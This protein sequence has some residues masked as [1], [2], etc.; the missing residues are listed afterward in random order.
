MTNDEILAEVALVSLREKA[1]AFDNIAIG[2][3]AG[4]ESVRR[5]VY[6]ACC[7]TRERD[8]LSA[9]LL[10]LQAAS[11]EAARERDG[12]RAVVEAVKVLPVAMR[13]HA[14]DS[15]RV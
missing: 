13:A 10:A 3:G 12:L 4:S 1:D 11:A 6:L 8:A 7:A 14:N 5:V 2:I 9:Q 15:R